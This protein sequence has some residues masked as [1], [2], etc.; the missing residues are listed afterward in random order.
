MGETG[1]STGRH[2]P[3]ISWRTMAFMTI[4]S[5]GSIAQLSASAEF[6]LGAV[7]LYLLPALL[8]LLPVALIAAELATG[9]GVV[10]AS[11]R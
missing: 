3:R 4:A 2:K 10:A 6:G 8:F 1:P 11:G 9:W 7:T 5:T